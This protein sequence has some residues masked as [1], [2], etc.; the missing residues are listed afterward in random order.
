MPEAAMA[1]WVDFTTVKQS[2]GLALVLRHYQ[3][4]LRRSG[5]DQYRGLCPIHQGEGRDAFHANL[6]RNVFIAFPAAPEARYWT[7]SPPWNAARCAKRR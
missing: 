3:V 5:R 1:N 4:S 7:L 2:V 6:T